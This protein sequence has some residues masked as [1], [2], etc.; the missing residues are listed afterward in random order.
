MAGIF[1]SSYKIGT[2]GGTVFEDIFKF[3]PLGSTENNVW[4]EFMGKDETY[5]PRSTK[6]VFDLAMTKR[7]AYVTQTDYYNQE[8]YCDI[9][10]I[11][12]VI[13]N[14]QSGFIWTKHLP[15]RHI[16][17]YYIKK[18]RENG[19]IQRIITKYNQKMDCSGAQANIETL[20]V[21]NVKFYFILMGLGFVL[22][23][24]ILF[25]EKCKRNMTRKDQDENKIE[26]RQDVQG[27]EKWVNFPREVEK[28][29]ETFES[30]NDITVVDGDV[31]K[32]QGVV[33]LN[34]ST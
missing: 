34:S 10:D 13:K 5:M 31:C 30:S 28:N 29:K 18:M 22:S 6:E 32:D 7:Y 16:L 3:A 24:M 21:E 33:T 8:G 27:E 2:K 1:D 17:N 9:I 20:S 23:M 19:Q 4:K 26:R 15:Q 14:L 12:Y 11:P 25:M